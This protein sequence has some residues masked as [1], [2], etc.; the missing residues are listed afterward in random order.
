[1]TIFR[2]AEVVYIFPS[3]PLGPHLFITKEIS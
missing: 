1:L 3:S 2:D